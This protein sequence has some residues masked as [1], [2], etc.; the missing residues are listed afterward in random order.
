MN[1]TNEHLALPTPCGSAT[2][3]DLLDHLTMFATNFG[4]VARK[5]LDEHTSRPPAAFDARNLGATWH[6]DVAS[7]LSAMADAWSVEDAWRDTTWVGGMQLP[8]EV[9]GVIALDELVV[10]GWDLAT[11]TSQEFAATD[12][13]VEAAIAFIS[14]FD[15][16]RDG[17]LFGP[18]VEVAPGATA[19][20][21]LLGLAGR[22]PYWQRPG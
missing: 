8:A 19:L 6:D 1:L 13:E 21:R 10:H 18:V 3:G 16:P 4:K 14:A 2:V 11:A 15:A 12:H 7:S 17:R 9:V 20:D 5:E 22:D